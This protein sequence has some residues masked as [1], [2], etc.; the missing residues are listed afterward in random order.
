MSLGIHL[1]NVSV[2]FWLGLTL[3]RDLRT[4]FLGAL[5]FAIQPGAT[6]AVVWI[7]AVTGLLATAFGLLALSAM[8]LSWSVTPSGRRT[9]VELTAL[10]SFACALFSHEAA[11]TFPVLAAA[12]WWQWGPPDAMRR[13][14][15]PFGAAA[16]VALFVTVTAIANARN[17]VFTESHYAIGLH[18]VRHLFEYIVALYVGP[19]WWLA[20]V[21]C[22]AALTVLLIATPV[23]RIGALWLLITLMPYV[24]FTWPNAGR[25]LYLPA[26]GFGWA[27]AGAV[28]AACDWTARRF[29]SRSLAL[30]AYAI[31]VA[32]VAIR[33]GRFDLASVRS[34]VQSMEPW[35]EYAAQLAD[36]S[37]AGGR[38][39]VEP[40]TDGIVDP[41]YVAS[42]ARWVHQDFDLVVDVR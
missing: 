41:M 15:L 32:F 1:V 31:V 29:G 13:P 14:V 4:A 26:I 12:I 6:Q 9:L 2:V 10:C 3:F 11:I 20:Y 40:P 28:T 22:A 38:V 23:T 17:Y 19:G 36:S 30:G 34:R 27:V 25:Y 33:F 8:V 16:V 42:M 37:P 21:A 35:R 39:R 24:W 7:S 5:L 18:G